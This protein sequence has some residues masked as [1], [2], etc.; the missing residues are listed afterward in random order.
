[1][2]LTREFGA[3]DL[4]EWREFLIFD[5]L[6]S[7]LESGNQAIEYFVHRD[8]SGETFGPVQQV[9]ELAEAERIL[10]GQGEDGGWP[11][12]GKRQ[13]GNDVTNHTLI[14]TWKRFLILIDKFEFNRDHPQIEEAAE[15]IFS[16]QTEAGDIRGMIGNQYATYYTGAFI[17]LLI[18]AGYAE[19]PRIEK[20]FQWLLNM[21]Q[22]DGG[23]SIPMI[24]H[25][26]D[27]ETQYRLVTE[28]VLPVEPDRSKPFSHNWT[29]MVLRAFAAH[30]RYRQ[31]DAAKRAA[32]LLKSRFFQKDAYSSYQS[33]GYWVR[34]EHPF[35][36]N[37]LVSALDTLS[38][39]GLSVEDP[40][41]RN[42]L[43]WLVEHQQED[44][45]WRLNYNKNEEKNTP[46][47]MEKQ[48]WVTLAICRIFKRFSDSRD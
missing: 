16:C 40:Q 46:K 48:L 38:R 20:G 11:R 26:F 8:L 45:L 30:D 44:G 28:D 5:P 2:A 31:T 34:F 1:M 17:A 18:K 37:N 36:W 39:L 41:I 25:K 23:W 24:T 22:E 10:R 32:V 35:W 3:A 29:G 14:E 15:Y 27:R 33:P 42:G 7:L 12:P 19:D 43:D 21:R 4:N 6:A 9:W 47:I 13:E